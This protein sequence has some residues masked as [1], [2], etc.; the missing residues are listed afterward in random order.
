M[1]GAT[2]F[3]PADCELLFDDA[4][5]ALRR[6]APGLVA[7]FTERGWPLPGSLDRV[8]DS[9]RAQRELGWQSQHGFE[10]VLDLL[11]S[12]L[13]EVLPVQLMGSE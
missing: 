2:P 10:S 9:T 7:A 1:S 4:P 11:D 6:H 5:E 3:T 12:E 13:A 8:Y